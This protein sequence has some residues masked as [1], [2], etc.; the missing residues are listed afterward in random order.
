MDQISGVMECSLSLSL[1]E[2][3][4]LFRSNK[5]VKDSHHAIEEN[6]PTRSRG[7]T[8]PLELSFR[9]KLVGEILG[10]YSQAHYKKRRL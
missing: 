5:K 1:D 3:N 6:S 4:K 7:S 10:A 2:E 8:Y 9:D